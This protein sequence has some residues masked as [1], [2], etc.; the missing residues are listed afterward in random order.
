M[1][2][3][4]KSKT[5]TKTKEFYCE[6]N[7]K[8]QLLAEYNTLRAEIVHRM[9][10]RHQIVSFSVV[11]LGAI[12]AFEVKNEITLLAYPILTLFLASGWAHNDCRIGE[13]IKQNIEDKLCFLNW[14]THLYETKNNELPLK[15]GIQGHHALSRWNFCGYADTRFMHSLFK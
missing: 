8:E 3:H 13:Y 6:N 11:L 2:E 12:L 9:G 5:L 4:S 15:N 10:I 14:E 1:E 7:C